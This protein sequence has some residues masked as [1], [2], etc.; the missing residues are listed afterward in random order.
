M[1]GEQTEALRFRSAT[2]HFLQ[3]KR[4]EACGNPKLFSEFKHPTISAIVIN[5]AGQNH[6]RIGSLKG[7]FIAWDARFGNNLILAITRSD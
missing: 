6:W 5:K 1:G 4:I 2:P 3:R 7:H